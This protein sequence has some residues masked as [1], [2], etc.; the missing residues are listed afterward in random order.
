M[1]THPPVEL[2][3]HI[4]ASVARIDPGVVDHDLLPV[5]AV[6]PGVAL[7]LD[8]DGADDLPGLLDVRRVISLGAGKLRGGVRSLLRQRGWLAVVVHVHAARLYLV[9]RA[10]AGVHAL[11]DD[12]DLAELLESGGDRVRRL[13]HVARV[14]DGIPDGVAIYVGAPEDW[15]ALVESTPGYV[16]AGVRRVGV[17]QGQVAH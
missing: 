14:L 7:D 1:L 4:G 17:R 13:D 10:A 5:L 3:P 11:L 15:V 12:V 8:A 16:V 6:A 9:E 2:E